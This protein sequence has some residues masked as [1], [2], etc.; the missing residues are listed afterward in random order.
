MQRCIVLSSASVAIVVMIAVSVV[1]AQDVPL[2][3][4]PS[5]EPLVV[6]LEEASP[7]MMPAPLAQ[8]DAASMGVAARH[9]DEFAAASFLHAIPAHTGGTGGT[10]FLPLIVRPDPYPPIDR[11]FELE[12]LRLLNETR[13][14]EGLQ[15]LVEDSRLTSAAR[16]HA[17]DL[18]INLIPNGRCGH[19]GSD[20]SGVLRR[21]RD[22][23]VTRFGSVGET[24]ACGNPSPDSVIH[25][26]LNS[27]PHRAILLLPEINRVGVGAHPIMAGTYLGWF[28]GVFVVI[29]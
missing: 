22:A 16:R 10:V 17:Y 28:S 6:A 8:S 20:G 13:I 3:P 4:V 9:P 11:A 2:P 1:A 18:G 7:P 25:S 29:S 12:M 23:G 5:P 15:P 19:I 27:P 21:V 26:L 24:V 14:R